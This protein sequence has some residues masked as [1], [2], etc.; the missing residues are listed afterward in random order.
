MWLICTQHLRH[1]E[2]TGITIAT[3]DASEALEHRQCI[4]SSYIW[5]QALRHDT[6]VEVIN[7]KD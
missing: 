2:R 3:E 6:Y 1:L 7:L 5:Y 4:I